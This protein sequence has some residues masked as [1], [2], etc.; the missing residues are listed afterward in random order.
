MT[1]CVFVPFLLIILLS[2]FLFY[3]NIQF[4]ELNAAH[5]WK[6]YTRDDVPKHM[7]WLDNNNIMRRS[8]GL[9][10]IRVRRINETNN[11]VC[12]QKEYA[13]EL[14]IVYRMYCQLQMLNDALLKRYTNDKELN[15]LQI[16]C[17]EQ[18]SMVRT[19]PLN[20]AQ[21]LFFDANIGYSIDND[22]EAMNELRYRQ[23]VAAGET[24][25]I[26]DQS[27]EFSSTKSPSQ[28]RRPPSERQ[29]QLYRNECVLSVRERMEA[30]FGSIL[31]K[32]LLAI[33]EA[34]PSIHCCICL[35]LIVENTGNRISIETKCCHQTIHR[36]CLY[37]WVSQTQT[38][39]MCRTTI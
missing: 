13:D 32:R 37:I 20:V 11:Y 33:K 25:N 8:T 12:T 19:I 24:G 10:A 16:L 1:L 3:T 14:S 38:C 29:C 7:D 30:Y 36:N 9:L 27:E 35:D 26:F 6:L 15:M 17:L 23:F 18:N 31:G 22:L 4:R 34:T 2:I 28:V 39:P 21:P 5:L